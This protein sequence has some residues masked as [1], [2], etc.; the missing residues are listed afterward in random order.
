MYNL[1]SKKIKTDQKMQY[2][3]LSDKYR[4]G[5]EFHDRLTRIPADTPETEIDD[6]QPN[7]KKKKFRIRLILIAVIF[8]FLLFAGIKNPSESESKDLIKHH[9]IE[10][11]NDLARKEES[12]N[13][14]SN[15]D[16]IITNRFLRNTLLPGLIDTMVT[17]HTSDY[18]FFSSFEATVEANDKKKNLMSGIILFGKVLPLSSDIDQNELNNSGN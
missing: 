17:I 11:I 5:G 6:K 15:E 1:D 16:A 14:E 2:T 13:P 3:R 10:F 7:N 4:A 12:Q 8:F 9:I 18:I